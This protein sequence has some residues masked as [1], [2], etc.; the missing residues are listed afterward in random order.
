MLQYTAGQDDHL[1]LD[2]KEGAKVEEER[3]AHAMERLLPAWDAVMEDEEADFG[4]RAW[5]VQVHRKTAVTLYNLACL[6]CREG[7][8]DAA[9]EWL[10]KA[11]DLDDGLR[12]NA[13]EDEDLAALRGGEE[14]PADAPR[15]NGSAGG[16]D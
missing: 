6:A 11:F 9:R 15:E 13:E 7:D 10:D 16:E 14:V 4:I 2:R 3:L 12:E 8:L 1:V 5:A